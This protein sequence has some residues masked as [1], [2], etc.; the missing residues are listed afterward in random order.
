MANEATAR[1]KNERNRFA[2]PFKLEWITKLVVGLLVELNRTKCGGEIAA[3]SLL[4]FKYLNMEITPFVKE[5]KILIQKEFY[6]DKIKRRIHKRHGAEE[7]Q[8]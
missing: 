4:C 7:L 8:S 1:V 3:T 5:S 6:Y 2:N